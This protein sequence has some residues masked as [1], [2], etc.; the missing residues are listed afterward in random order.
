VA[1][2]LA[3]AVVGCSGQHPQ[4]ILT[5]D[6]EAPGAVAL[7]VRL[8]D[9][10]GPRQEVRSVGDADHPVALP[11]TVYL[12][13]A[14]TDRI[15]V[16][17]WVADEGGTIVAQATTDSCVA[18]GSASYTL[19]L[20]PAPDGWS[21]ASLEPCRCDGTN[22]RCSATVTADGGALMDAGPLAADAGAD[23]ADDVLAAPPDAT[24]DVGADGPAPVDGRPPDGPV[25]VATDA[26]AVD[27]TV[28]AP[29][30]TRDLA[31]DRAADTRAPTPVSVPND[32]FGFE[33]TGPDWT[34]AETALVRDTRTK[35]EGAASLQ[36]TVPAAGTTTL[37][38]RSFATGDLGVG[39][40]TQL[41]VDIFVT[42]KQIGDANTELWVDCQSAGVYG[43]Y[44]GYKALT[45]LR[46]GGWT[47]VTFK[48]PAAVVTAFKGKFS[49]CQV[50]FQ[51]AGKGLFRYDR[52]G[53]AP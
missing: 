27:V 34:S 48:M 30:L 46:A 7:F 2:L 53:F 14:H 33:R 36:F 31:V 26:G 3:L 49:D 20:R 16:A 32:L 11:A 23:A 6:G 44:L 18:T 28:D 35:T 10:A 25:V 5:V 21:P 8:I 50:S 38:S 22:L 12:Q 40:S 24:G 51:L 43:V 37:K 19:T 17:V 9:E 4:V 52:L 47:P 29:A 41:S 45:A 13:L 15:G 42:D 1:A 39:A